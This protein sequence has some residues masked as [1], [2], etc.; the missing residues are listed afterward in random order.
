M[1]LFSVEDDCSSFCSGL[2]FDGDVFICLII[3]F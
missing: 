2:I 3:V 1:Y